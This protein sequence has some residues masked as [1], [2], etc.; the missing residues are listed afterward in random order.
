[1]CGRQY[2]RMVDGILQNPFFPRWAT[3]QMVHVYDDEENPEGITQCVDLGTV[4]GGKEAVE[5]R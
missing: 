5:V 4:A 1:M 3:G 2:L